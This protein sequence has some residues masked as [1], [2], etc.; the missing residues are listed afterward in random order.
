MSATYL[1][2][3]GYVAKLV[4][5]GVQ[6]NLFEYDYEDDMDIQNAPCFNQVAAP[7]GPLS[8]VGY[9]SHT[10]GLITGWCSGTGVFDQLT[11]TVNGIKVGFDGVLAL[12]INNSVVSS[13][14]HAI[15]KRWHVRS[16]APGQTIVSGFWI[17]DETFTDFA[18][19]NA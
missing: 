2:T 10:P 9:M 8:T 12:Y 13:S 3:A 5:N 15:C 17:Y 4:F 11:A 18:N 14:P 6:L 19:T 7:R 16:S 1:P